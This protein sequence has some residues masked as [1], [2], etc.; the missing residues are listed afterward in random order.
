MSLRSLFNKTALIERSTASRAA[1]GEVSRSWSTVADDVPCALRSL[2][3]KNI[4]TGAGFAVEADFVAFLP[5]DTDIQT[6]SGG[7]V[8][9]R[10]TIDSVKYAVV[11]ATSAPQRDEYVAAY[12]KRRA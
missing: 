12:L 1:T 9:D 4:L 5:P 7:G 10:I 6:D 8:P 2:S 11:F 3:G